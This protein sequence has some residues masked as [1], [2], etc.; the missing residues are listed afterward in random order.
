M[1][2]C[3]AAANH[4]TAMMSIVSEDESNK[5]VTLTPKRTDTEIADDLKKRFIAAFEALYPF[6][7][8]A[9]Q[10]DMTINFGMAADFL[11]RGR[12]ANVQIVKVFF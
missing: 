8:E 12:L 6:F 7:D 10:H 11:G 2:E 5:V 9:K 1:L 4:G 3:H